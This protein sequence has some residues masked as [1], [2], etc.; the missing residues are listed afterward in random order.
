VTDRLTL[1]GR[2]AWHIGNLDSEGDRPRL[3]LDYNVFDLVVD[4]SYAIPDRTGVLVGARGGVSWGSVTRWTAPSGATG[5]SEREGEVSWDGSSGV[6]ELFTGAQYYIS[7]R[8]VP[9]VRVGYAFR[10]YG[11]V[12]EAGVGFDPVDLNFGGWF[13]EI[14]FE[15]YLRVN[16]TPS[17]D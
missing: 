17:Y 2:F 1:G 12:G 13:I 11:E 7:D 4:V 8:A 9:S 14:G 6:V 16:A 15:G 10:D 5:G 3:E